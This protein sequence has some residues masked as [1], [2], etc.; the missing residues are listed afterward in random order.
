MAVH[1]RQR[2]F[3]AAG[4]GEADLFQFAQ[5]FLDHG[6]KGGAVHQTHLADLFGQRRLHVFGQG[7]QRQRRTFGQQQPHDH[8]RLFGTGQ[9]AGHGRWAGMSA[10]RADAADLGEHVRH[11]SLLSL[12]GGWQ[13]AG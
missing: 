7:G 6:A 4:E 12:A 9:A 10:A 1:H 3:D 11:A 2:A 5:E 8:R 13:A